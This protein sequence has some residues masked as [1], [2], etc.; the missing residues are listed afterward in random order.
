MDYSDKRWL[1]KRK[2]ILNRDKNL[3]Q[4]MLRQGVRVAAT[5]VHHILPAE[6]YPEYRYCDWNL[7]SISER[8]HKQIMHEKYTGKLAKA[9]RALMLETAA[10]NGIKLTETILVCGKP[11][12]GKSTWTKQ[13]L[14]GG[15]CYDLDAIA[16]AFRLTVPHKE[17]EHA[18]S[19]RM[20]AALRSGFIKLAP[21]YAK[22]LIVIR[23]APDIAEL[24]ETNPDRIVICNKIKE[25]RRIDN[26]AEIDSRLDDIVKWAAINNVS[27][28]YEPPGV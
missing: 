8:T 23:T 12:T 10:R 22:R 24:S 18:A 11:G 14:K 13:N 27:V 26:E 3:D 5:V 2:H 21:K 4:Y 19:R 15:V 20:A 7:I 9:G 17:E 16:A 28:E 1:Q 6:D 25:V